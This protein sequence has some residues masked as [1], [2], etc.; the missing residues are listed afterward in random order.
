MKRIA[1]LSVAL[2]LSMMAAT[3]QNKVGEFSIKPLAGINVSDI[4]AD[5]EVNY[6]AKSAS[7]EAWRQSMALRLGSVFPWERC[8]RSREQ[9]IMLP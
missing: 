8:I 6:K 2:M 7:Q 4:S 5:D 1:I 9:N 3:A